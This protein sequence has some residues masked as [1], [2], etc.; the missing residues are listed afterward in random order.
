V[1]VL[2]WDTASQWLNGPFIALLASEALPWSTSNSAYWVPVP[3]HRLP[4]ALPLA[5][6]WSPSLTR[7]PPA[8]LL[9]CWWRWCLS[10]FVCAGAGSVL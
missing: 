1:P 10:V 5:A 9:C 7:L 8:L 3:R 4:D 6:L 2:Q